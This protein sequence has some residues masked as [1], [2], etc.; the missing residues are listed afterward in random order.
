MGGG[1]EHIAFFLVIFDTDQSRSAVPGGESVR[2]SLSPLEED[3]PRPR[4]RHRLAATDDT[5]GRFEQVLLV[6]ISRRTASN[7][8]IRGFR[9][10]CKDSYQLGLSENPIIQLTTVDECVIRVRIGQIVSFVREPIRLIDT[11]LQ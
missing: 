7:R 11:G 2:R 6:R 9:F 4:V 1:N 8:G 5:S 10:G 3:L